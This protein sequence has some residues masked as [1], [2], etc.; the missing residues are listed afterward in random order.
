MTIQGNVEAKSLYHEVH[1][2]SLADPEGFWA[3]AAKDAHRTVTRS[4]RDMASKD[5]NCSILLP[6]LPRW[7]SPT[8]SFGNQTKFR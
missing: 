6:F 4:R 2:R 8:G 3:E 5:S 7:T 1:A